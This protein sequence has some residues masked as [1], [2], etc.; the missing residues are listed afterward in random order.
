MGRESGDPEA[1][2]SSGQLPFPE[3]CVHAK[4]GLK[5]SQW[6]A[7]RSEGLQSRGKTSGCREVG[8]G[9]PGHGISAPAEVLGVW[10]EDLAI[11]EEVEMLPGREEWGDTPSTSEGRSH[12]DRAQ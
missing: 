2:L 10:R 11:Q 8:C 12:L 5:T 7:L 1:Y 3:H 4:K 6:S 9:G